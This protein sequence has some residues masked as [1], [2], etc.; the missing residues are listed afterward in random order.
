MKKLIN[1]YAQK[2]AE[3]FPERKRISCYLPLQDV[4]KLRSIGDGN[5]N[6][7]LQICLSAFEGEFTVI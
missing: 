2:E 4:E 5:F 6:R 3:K 7:G 1:E